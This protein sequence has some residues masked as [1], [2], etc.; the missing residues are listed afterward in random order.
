M[1]KIIIPIE[2]IKKAKGLLKDYKLHS[3]TLSLRKAGGNY[4]AEKPTLVKEKAI[5]ITRL[6]TDF[7]EFHTDKYPIG[8]E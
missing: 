1:Y 4:I 7:F 5:R 2:E 3:V 8:G 6:G